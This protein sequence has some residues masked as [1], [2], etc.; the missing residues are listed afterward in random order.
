MCRTLVVPRK[1]WLCADR[2]RDRGCAH[3]CNTEDS[4][5]KEAYHGLNKG[6]LN[7]SRM[8]HGTIMP[9]ASYGPLIVY[10][11][12]GNGYNSVDSTSSLRAARHLAHD[13]MIYRRNSTYTWIVHGRGAV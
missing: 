3:T 2:S 6:Y 4:R 12:T 11:H 9:F 5:R 7:D 8:F 1:M 10:K 13:F